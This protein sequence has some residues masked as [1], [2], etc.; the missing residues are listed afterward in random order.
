MKNRQAELATDELLPL[1]M[2][3]AA[4]PP[5]APGAAPQAPAPPAPFPPNFPATR[6]ALLALHGPALDALLVAYN[7]PIVGS[8]VQRKNRLAGLLGMRCPIA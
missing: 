7:L 3:V 2:P 1:R 6:G 8:V 4:V 5:V